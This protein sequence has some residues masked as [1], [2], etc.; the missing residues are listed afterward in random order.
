MFCKNGLKELRVDLKCFAPVTANHKREA[1]LKSIFVDLFS[2]NAKE[3]IA[4]NS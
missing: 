2:Q 4:N 3:I 1:F